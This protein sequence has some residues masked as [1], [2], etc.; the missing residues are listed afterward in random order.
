M[1]SNYKKIVTVTM[2]ATNFKQ[3]ATHY[4]CTAI[5][6]FQTESYAF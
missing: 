5:R 2:T 6:K 1:R 3:N 4:K